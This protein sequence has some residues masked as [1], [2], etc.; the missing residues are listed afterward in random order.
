MDEMLGMTEIIAENEAMKTNLL[1]FGKVTQDAKDLLTRWNEIDQII[2]KIP[3][4]ENFS[5][6]PIPNTVE[7]T[8]QTLPQ[9]ESYIFENADSS[10]WPMKNES[11][12]SYQSLSQGE[13]NSVE[14]SY[15]G[16]HNPLCVTLSHNFVYPFICD[17]RPDHTVEL[18][19]T[20]PREI[21]HN[22]E[23][24]FE[25]TCGTTHDFQ[26]YQE[27]NQ[28]GGPWGNEFEDQES[29]YEFSAYPS[30]PS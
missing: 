1:A 12:P 16:P 7:Q 17:S 3:G 30:I 28:F 25:G 15:F 6:Q 10:P 4:L 22:F 2:A 20:M 11:V 13:P 23:Y 27:E 8:Y 29:G 9:G 26:G 21:G 5:S 19:I 14:I 18:S 24:K